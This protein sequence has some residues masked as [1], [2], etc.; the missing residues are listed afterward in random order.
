MVDGRDAMV[1]ERRE[2]RSWLFKSRVPAGLMYV[3]VVIFC[4]SHSLLP[5][6]RSFFYSRKIEKEKRGRE[7]PDDK[8]IIIIIMGRPEQSLLAVLWRSVFY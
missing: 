7:H 5:N 4:G 8:N 3:V 6:R 1:D 2:A